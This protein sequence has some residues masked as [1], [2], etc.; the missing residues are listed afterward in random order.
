MKINQVEELV[1]ITKKNIR[2]YED[3]GLINPNRNA[4]NGYREYSLAD[5]DRLMKI[6]LLR[7][8][9]IPIE[10][11]RMVL[12]GVLSLDTCLEEHQLVLSHRAHDLEIM[13]KLCGDLADEVDD[14]SELNA[15]KYF[16]EM[17]HMEEEGVHFMD[18]TKI[19]TKKVKRG[20]II[21][22]ICSIGFLIA[23]TVLILW[24]NTKEP[25]PTVVI[26]IVLLFVAL[27]VIGIIYS[28]TQRLQEIDGGEMYE[29]SK[30]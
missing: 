26:I 14:L 25:A 28:L 20:P 21:A 24:A 22:A 18:V 2:Y 17:R 8:L 19:D 15:S 23:M 5:V 10:K 4:Q 11:I 29:A 16:E 27:A 6:K 3:E 9:D 12:M 30:Y 7:Q 1:G 13:K